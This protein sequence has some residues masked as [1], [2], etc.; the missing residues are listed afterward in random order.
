[1]G[2]PVA[3]VDMVSGLHG[4]VRTPRGLAGGADPRREGV[5]LSDGAA[6]QSRIRSL[7]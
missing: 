7:Q 1:M 5:A 3:V 6:R 2:H 4:I